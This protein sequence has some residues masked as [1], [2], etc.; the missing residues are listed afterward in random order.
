MAKNS[1]GRLS[2]HSFG[3]SSVY[4]FGRFVR[5]F[6]S[7]IRK[8]VQSQTWV[9]IRYLFD[10]HGHKDYIGE[11]ISQ[12]AH[13]V[14][15]ARL[16]QT[17]KP[18]S[19]HLMAAGLL[20]DIGQLVA[21]EHRENGYS[22]KMNEYGV[23]HHEHIGAL[24]LKNWGFPPAIYQLV[25]SHVMA[26]R[27]LMTTD[28]QYCHFVSPA[29]LRTFH[30]QGGLLSLSQIQTFQQT[31]YF[32]HAVALRRMDDQAKNISTKLPVEWMEDVDELL[33]EIHHS[34]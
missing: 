21:L 16:A 25:R 33:T 1:F 18:Y 20:H 19:P 6:V 9:H 12:V 30:E 27:Y 24:A 8:T 13:A 7:M 10:H 26:K 11:S 17:V 28:P 29:S 2:V 22:L 32:A 15:T 34:L 3:R 31:K 5:L 4:S 14:Q 23:F